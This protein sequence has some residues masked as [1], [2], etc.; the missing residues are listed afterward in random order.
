MNNDTYWFARGYYDARNP[1]GHFDQTLVN[2]ISDACWY[3][4][5]R[6]FQ[7][8]ITDSDAHDISEAA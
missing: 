7:A 3:A 4:Y 2:L 1:N 5:D 6:G 8:G